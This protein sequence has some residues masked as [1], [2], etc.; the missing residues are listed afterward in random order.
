M[1]SGPQTGL[2]IHCSLAHSAVWGPMM[3]H[4]DRL[5][6][7][8]AF[9]MP[10]HGRS[11]DWAEGG[12]FQDTCCA[13]AAKLLQRPAHV[14]GHSFGAT[15]A[16]RL[17]QDHPQKVQSLTLI[18][19]VYFAAVKGTAA[20]PEYM[21]DF[22]PFGL[23]LDRGDLHAAARLFTDMWGAGVDW[24]SQSD[25]QKSQVTKRIHMIPAGNSAIL[26][27]VAGVLAAGRLENMRVPTL[28]I[29]GAESPKIIASIQD[30][31]QRRM[32]NTRRISVPG[33][34]HMVP[35]THPA[36]VAEQFAAFL[37]GIDQS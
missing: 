11:G 33:A 13:I 12:D 20:F 27:D 16:M 34:S 22:E 7:A 37:R 6:T 14:I 21:K 19:P 5:V 29:E 35:I 15:V 10:G 26:E 3:R 28:L 17:A 25:P 30:V 4:L 31:L 23:A 32:P 8:T 18:E 24:Q 9:D 2:L 36:I 1:G